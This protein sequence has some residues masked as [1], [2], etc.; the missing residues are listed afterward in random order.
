M[1]AKRLHRRQKEIR[2]RGSLAAGWA[3]SGA[4]GVGGML[5][6]GLAAVWAGSG[7]D[8]ALG[9][10]TILAG[11]VGADADGAL[12]STSIFAG[13]AAPGV[14]G[15]LGS[16]T[17]W[18]RMRWVGSGSSGDLRTIFVASGRGWVASLVGSGFVVLG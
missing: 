11:C 2:R 10:T 12:G 14:A 15:V 9:F 4:G 13:W 7:V 17:V 3:G 8:G 18:V 6:L 16:V 5:A 1:P